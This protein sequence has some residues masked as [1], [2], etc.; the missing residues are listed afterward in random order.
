MQIAAAFV[1]E[2]HL[3]A[4]RADAERNRFAEK[5]QPNAFQKLV[6]A[7]IESLR[8]LSG[9]ATPKLDAYPYTN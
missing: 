6:N 3:S 8:G 9:P 7:A 4:L 5:G 2:A 1:V